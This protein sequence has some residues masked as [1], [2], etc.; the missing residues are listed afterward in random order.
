[1]NSKKPL[2][3]RFVIYVN[4]NFENLLSV[5]F[6]NGATTTFHHHLHILSTPPPVVPAPQPMHPSPSPPIPSFPMPGQLPPAQCP[7]EHRH[8]R[9]LSIIRSSHSSTGFGPYL[10]SRTFC[11]TSEPSSILPSQT[12][13]PTS[14]PTTA[15]IPLVQIKIRTS[16]QKGC[17]YFSQSPQTEASISSSSSCSACPIRLTSTS[18][19]VIHSSPTIQSTSFHLFAITGTTTS[20]FPY[21][22]TSTTNLVLLGHFLAS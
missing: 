13:P 21:T 5:N 11:C 12:S 8:T 10:T 7:P 2:S 9:F 6:V 1:M 22:Y 18:G 15:Y 19:F 20:N 4:N 16:G 17:L 3:L 14:L